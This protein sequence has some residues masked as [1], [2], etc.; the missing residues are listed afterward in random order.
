MTRW[1]SL[2]PVD[3]EFFA[4]APHIF[5][6][7]KP[8]AAPPEQ[9]W[10]SL[11][12]D[13]SAAAWGRLIKEVSWTS[14]PPLGV[15]ATRESAALGTRARERYF[16][17]DEGHGYSMFVYESTA[18]IFKRY[19]EDFVLQHN[20]VGTLFNWTVAI[21]PKAAFALPFK[22]LAPLFRTLLGR[23]ASDGQRYFAKQM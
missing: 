6:Y 1:Y 8:F 14:A 17:W 13:A 23:I 5:G 15:G 12:S 20:D 11:I 10:E 2:E 9:V 22:A 4:S 19:A 3:A 7:Q 16:R 21:E 18:P